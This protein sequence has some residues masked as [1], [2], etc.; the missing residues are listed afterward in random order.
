MIGQSA[1]EK[2]A[3]ISPRNNVFWSYFRINCLKTLIINRK[4]LE[5]LKFFETISGFSLG[6][7]QSNTVENYL[8]SRETVPL[9]S[10]FSYI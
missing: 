7:D 4:S 5:L 10:A 1:G 9:S 2:L 8:E 3:K 6:L